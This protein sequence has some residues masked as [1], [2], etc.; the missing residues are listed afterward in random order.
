MRT[1]SSPSCTK[2]HPRFC[3]SKLCLS[4]DE[5]FI[6]LTR[7]LE[8]PGEHASMI[9]CASIDAGT[10]CTSCSCLSEASLGGSTSAKMDR[11]GPWHLTSGCDP[12]LLDPIGSTAQPPSSSFAHDDKSSICHTVFLEPAL[13][14]SARR[15]YAGGR[16]MPTD[17][18]RL[19]ACS[20]I[21][22][23]SAMVHRAAVQRVS[24]AN[25]SLRGAVVLDATVD[26]CQLL[27][28]FC[29]SSSVA[30]KRLPRQPRFQ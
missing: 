12:C 10:A 9:P 15:F 25:W 18:V 1:A 4:N 21:S 5:T 29:A 22:R 20:R 19:L 23:A 24:M 8:T 16:F 11:S 30:S 7:V 2:S 17:R 27:S 6:L 26:P 28:R 13:Q 14:E 3:K